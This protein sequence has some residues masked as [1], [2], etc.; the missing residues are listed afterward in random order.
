M[1]APIVKPNSTRGIILLWVCTDPV[2]TWTSKDMADELEDMGIPRPQTMAAI[3]ALRQ[4]GLLWPGDTRNRRLDRLRATY[5]GHQS[6]REQG[7]A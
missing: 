1:S 4:R 7:A 2:N 5:D 6:I 3:A